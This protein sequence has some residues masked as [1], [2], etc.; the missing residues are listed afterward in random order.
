M[1][2]WVME[3]LEASVVHRDVF[4]GF[5]RRH[6]QVGMCWLQSGH[7]RRS[8]AIKIDTWYTQGDLTIA[9]LVDHLACDSWES[10]SLS[11]G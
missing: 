9:R 11:H 3:Q 1:C 6:R 4:F 8:T 10:Q 5:V 7:Q 2:E